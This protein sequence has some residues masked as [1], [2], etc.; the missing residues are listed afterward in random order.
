MNTQYRKNLKA[1]LEASKSYCDESIANL[2]W[3]IGT[4]NY[5]VATDSNV[6]RIKTLPSDTYKSQID[7]IGGKTVK[8]NQL[9]QNGNFESVD[10]WTSWV[11]GNQYS[12][13][14]NE[15][16]IYGLTNNDISRACNVPANHKCLI[17]YDI[18]GN[19]YS[20]NT[21]FGFS[22]SAGATTAKAM[23]TSYQTISAIITTL[24]APTRFYI[25]VQGNNANNEAWIRRV[26]LIDLTSI[27]GAGNEPTSVETA[28]SLLKANGYKLDGTDTYST[29]KLKHAVVSGVE[30]RPINVWSYGDTGKTASDTN[31]HTNNVFIAA[32]T[33]TMS[34]IVSTT[35]TTAPAIRVAFRNQNGS[36]ITAISLAVGNARTPQTFTLTEDCYFVYFYANQTTTPSSYVSTFTDIMLVKGTTTPSTYIPY[37]APITKAIPSEVLALDGYGVGLNSSLYN[38]VDFNSKKFKKV[39]KKYT[40]K[41]TDAY[42]YT[43]NG[44]RVIVSIPETELG[45][46]GTT[47]G[48]SDTGLNFVVNNYDSNG[49][50]IAT[51]STYQQ[52]FVG[53]GGVITDTASAKEYLVGKTI[54]YELVT[55]IETD[56]SQYLTTDFKVDLNNQYAT[57]EMVC[58]NS[59]DM[60]NSITNL[61]K[62][63]KA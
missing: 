29:G 49:I 10:G 31:W 11:Y 3:Q 21:Y 26:E 6:A 12:I 33:Y 30:Y 15:C 23:T 27:F 50:Y 9:V 61:I 41:D 46:V 35:D 20:T 43:E 59:I 37:V 58:E 57:C 38:Y 22:N 5:D 32:G 47:N 24:A 19:E 17:S 2:E 55:P 44:H 14:N 7:Y 39:V 8:Y 42:S 40:F 45:V 25:Y 13:N 62:E 53:Y 48:T 16:H 18:K 63:V 34:A 56:I 4:Y 54:C 28:I 36:S 51:S 1:V 60:P 52:I